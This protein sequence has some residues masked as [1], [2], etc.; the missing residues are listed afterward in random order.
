MK[1]L[2][3]KSAIALSFALSAC[4]LAPQYQRPQIAMP[5]GWTNVAGVGV[6]DQP[7]TVP[8][9]QEL[10]SNELNNVMKVALAQN[11]D[12]EAALHRIDQARAQ[13]K[14]AG[15]SLFP[16]I[17]ASG[18]ASRSFQ[19]PRNVSIARGIGSISYEADLWGRNR[20]NRTAANYRAEAT[21]FDRDA[22]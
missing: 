11:L 16:Q 7:A 9:W 20:S 12:L 18:G 14:I 4:S 22:L 13:T 1:N 10:G 6:S 19:D 2:R 15:S 17:E 21:A 8:F 5:A 3:L